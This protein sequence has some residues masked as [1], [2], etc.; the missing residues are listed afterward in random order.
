MR[1]L[2]LLLICTLSVSLQAQER[3]AIG[4]TTF[5]LAKKMKF[6]I[7]EGGYNLFTEKKHVKSLNA[8]DQFIVHFYKDKI[9]IQKDKKVFVP[10]QR[11]HLEAHD[12]LG[13]F[14][15]QAIHANIY[16][17]YFGDLSIEA[18]SVGKKWINTLGIDDYIPGVLRG[19]VNGLVDEEFLKV[20]AIICRTYSLKNKGSHHH[21]G[22][23]LCEETH[24]QVYEGAKD[25]GEVY[26]NA[27]AATSGL[28]V[29]DSNYQLIDAVYHSN[30]GGVTAR[31]DYAWNNDFSYLQMQEDS[32]SYC[33]KKSEWE[34]EVSFD[35]WCRFFESHDRPHLDS[36][37]IDSGFHRRNYVIPGDSVIRMRDIRRH[38][39]L[40]SSFFEWDRT[41][42]STITIC[43]RGYGHGVGMAQ[44]GA[45]EMGLQGFDFEQILHFYYKGV[46]LEC[47][48]DL[49]SLQQSLKE[50]N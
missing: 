7:L 49:E 23:D 43:G 2:L 21:E 47:L 44:E 28:V 34:K 48:E 22:F 37:C 45:F 20:M 17:P 14:S 29:V 15:V 26:Y 39:K 13:K 4:L 33:G 19:E 32:F 18:D 5:R 9:L 31:A 25:I 30:S 42:D 38:F 36:M 46:K 35:E 27:V 6:E 24:C 50:V 41:D 8:G 1:K 16:Y 3:I 40:R 12:T 11:L 10:S